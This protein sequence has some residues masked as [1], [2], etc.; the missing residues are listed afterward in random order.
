MASSPRRRDD[1]PLISP[2]LIRGR[3]KVKLRTHQRGVESSGESGTIME[4]TAASREEA[5]MER[6]SRMM[7]E[8]FV[9]LEK[10]LVSRMLSSPP[11]SPVAEQSVASSL[12][13][14]K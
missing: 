12:L 1:P 7:E 14:G 10:R 5:L 13:S 3:K 9:S 8:K 11:V 2:P 4:T 6:M